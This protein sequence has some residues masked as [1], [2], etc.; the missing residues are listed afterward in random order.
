MGHI[1]LIDDSLFNAMVAGMQ[2]NVKS[3]DVVE[4]ELAINLEMGTVIASG[5]SDPALYTNSF[6]KALVAR[7]SR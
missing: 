1:Y 6:M 5:G 7:A 2:W 3:S 4:F